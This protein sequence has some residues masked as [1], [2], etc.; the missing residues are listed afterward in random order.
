MC[1]I[2]KLENLS[3]SADLIPPHTVTYTQNTNPEHHQH[4]IIWSL[5]LKF[6]Q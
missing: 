6:R 3:E 2:N 5:S 4:L 1:Y